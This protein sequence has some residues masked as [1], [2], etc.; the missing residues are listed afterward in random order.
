MDQ[1]KQALI[2]SEIERIALRSRAIN[3]AAIGAA[4]DR[5]GIS[6]DDMGRVAGIEDAIRALQAKSPELFTA[7]AGAP[8]DPAQTRATEAQ[9]TADLTGQTAPAAPSVA[10]RMDQAIRGKLAR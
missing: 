1:L 9:A 8:H 6:V 10:S 2:N 3:T 7:T 4:I 5:A